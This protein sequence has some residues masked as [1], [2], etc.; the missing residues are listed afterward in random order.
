MP[1]KGLTE[2]HHLPRIGKIHLGVKVKPEGKAEYPKA[3]DYFVWPEPDAL[4]G[5]LRDQLIDKYGDKPKELRIVLPLNDED[6]VASQYYRCYTRTRGLVCRGDGENAQ[7]MVDTE[8]GDLPSKD[9]KDTKM[10]TMLCQGRD[11]PDYGGKV[12]CGE[13]MN[14]QF[15]LPDISGLGV[16]QIDTGSINSI[17]N[18]NGNLAMIRQLYGRID[19]VPLVLAIEPQ[20]VT[21]PGGTKKTVHV[22]NMRHGDTLIEAVQKARLTPH[23]LIAGPVDVAQAEKD[24]DELWPKS[25]Q[26]V[27]LSPEEAAE[28]QTPDEI[29]KAKVAA[30]PD[31][32]VTY[33]GQLDPMP[34]GKPG[35]KLCIIETEQMLYWHH[36]A[37]G[38][39][40]WQRIPPEQAQEQAEK[41]QVEPYEGMTFDELIAWV[42]GHGRKEGWLFKTFGFNVEKA[43]AKPYACAMEVKE[44]MGW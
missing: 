43:K 12:G 14:L 17:R 34:V 32:N 30:E 36:H 42:K 41:A 25:E 15:M 8:T 29:V 19:L 39:G 20:E 22:L 1:I 38:K 35:D 7:R 13:V 27:M 26:E 3:V 5:H 28:R 10:M 4:G 18:I 24:I 31:V 33:I 44:M 23:E 6:M 16:W 9:T 21:P 40:S 37:A 2:S 11:C